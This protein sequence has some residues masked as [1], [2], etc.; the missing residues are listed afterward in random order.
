VDHLSLTARNDSFVQAVA[1]ILT[2]ANYSVDYYAGEKVT[3]DFYRN[4]PTGEYDIVVLRVHSAPVIENG[5]EGEAVNLFTSESYSASSHVAEQLSH[6]VVVAEYSEGSSQYFGIAPSFVK[7]RMNGNFAN[8]TVIMMGCDGLT[9]K[10]TAQAFIEKGAKAYIGWNGPVTASHT[11]TAT[12]CLLENLFCGNLTIAEAVDK[13]YRDV[14]LDPT[15]FSRLT[16][17]PP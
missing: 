6:E 1:D 15:Y 12:T 10:V 14:G 2:E 13:T 5:S 4:L 11:D 3:V 7:N 16:N 17:Y 9:H 8:A